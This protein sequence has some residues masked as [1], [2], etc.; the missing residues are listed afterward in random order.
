M[1]SFPVPDNAFYFNRYCKFIQYYL[2]NPP[3]DEYTETH[4]I[5]P[6]CMGEDDSSSNLIKLL[7][8]AHYI[9]HW[10][11]H[12]SFNSPKLTYAF[13][14]MN[15]G[16]VYQTRTI[17]SRLYE[18][19]KKSYS[20]YQSISKQGENNHYYGKKHS[21]EIRQ[22]ISNSKKGRPNNSW[23]TGQT[24]KTNEKLAKVGANISKAVIGMRH[25]TDGVTTRKGRECP[26]DGWYIGRAPS[27][28]FS[29]SPEEKAAIKERLKN[30]PPKW[31]NNGQQNKRSAESPG[32][33]WKQGRLMSHAHISKMIS[34]R[35]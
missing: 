6:R 9:A 13:M 18:S 17:N 11:L 3:Y 33:E 20:T 12:K 35:K 2:D 14:M 16:N 8:R 31:W 32:P 26:G 5:L 15:C 1:F 27:S 28:K 30:N 7:G 29:R 21:T 24:A 10:L 25:W 19:A 22:K 34:N 4:H 23:N